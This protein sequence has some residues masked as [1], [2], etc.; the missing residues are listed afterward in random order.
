MTITM[1]KFTER[2]GVMPILLLG[3]G[4]FAIGLL[5]GQHIV[6]NW[7]PFNVSRLDLVRATALDRTDS[8]ALLEA[9]NVDIILAFLAVIL[10]AVTG[11]VMPLTF[12]LNRRFLRSKSPFGIAN[13]PFMVTLR[14]S[15]WVGLWATF[16]VWLQ[17]NRLLSIALAFL[18]A[19]VLIMFELLLHI[20]TRAADL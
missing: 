5:A 16:C 12:I 3:S 19:V 18:I 15:M 9:A 1:S 17:M 14:Q 20:R 7:W 10:V 11:L 6:N 4:L 2:L 13:P 8:A